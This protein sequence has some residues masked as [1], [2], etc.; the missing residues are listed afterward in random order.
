[1]KQLFSEVVKN[2]MFPYDS[3]I[4]EEANILAYHN[5]LLHYVSPSI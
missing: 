4:I 1:M 3:Q 2:I 5:I